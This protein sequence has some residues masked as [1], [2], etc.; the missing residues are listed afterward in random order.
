MLEQYIETYGHWTV[1]MGTSLEGGTVI[2]PV[3]LRRLLWQSQQRPASVLSGVSAKQ[4]R[5]TPAP[6][7]EAADRECGTEA[8]SLP[9][10]V[11]GV[12][13]IS[14]GLRAVT[15]FMVGTPLVTA[16]VFLILNILARYRI[17]TT[18]PCYATLGQGR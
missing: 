9:Q 3:S 5:A 10:P 7:L 2:N 8:G 16:L 17:D 13:T 4:F 18:I 6:G 15:P 14:Y 12:V 11:S 1:L